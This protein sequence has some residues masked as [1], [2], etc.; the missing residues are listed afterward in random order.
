M[1]KSDLRSGMIVEYRNGVRRLVLEIQGKIVLSGINGYNSLQYTDVE[2][3]CMG[4]DTDI[5]LIREITQLGSIP[6]MLNDNTYSVI[7][8]QLPNNKTRK[9]T[10]REVCEMAG[11]NVEIIKND[12]SQD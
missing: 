12:A 10:M 3:S 6:D 1:Q 2:L 9:M 7:I 5:V 8:W 4:R 11:C